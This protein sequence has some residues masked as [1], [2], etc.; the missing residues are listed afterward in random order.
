MEIRSSVFSAL[1]R[2]THKRR[3]EFDGDIS[4][5]GVI[6]KRKGNVRGSHAP[7][8]FVLLACCCRVVEIGLRIEN[9]SQKDVSVSLLSADIT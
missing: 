9:F 6:R 7:V 4:P 1:H 5:G 2:M 8:V 3:Q